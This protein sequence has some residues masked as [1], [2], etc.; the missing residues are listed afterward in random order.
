MQLLTRYA[1][2]T[3]ICPI[4]SNTNVCALTHLQIPSELL[5]WCVIQYAISDSTDRLH[6]L[7]T[8][9]AAR[10]DLGDLADA[11]EAATRAVRRMATINSNTQI[12]RVTSVISPH[13]ARLRMSNKDHERPLDSKRARHM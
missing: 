5:R 9:W 1:A 3:V 13:L 4:V 11:A 12:D 7:M 8:F 6:V 10:P 2:R